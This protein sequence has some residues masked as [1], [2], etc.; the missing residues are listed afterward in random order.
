MQ[1]IKPKTSHGKDS[2]TTKSSRYFYFSIALILVLPHS[3]NRLNGHENEEVPCK[4]KDLS[5]IPISQFLTTRDPF[6]QFQFPPVFHHQASDEDN[7]TVFV[8]A[9]PNGMPENMLKQHFTAFGGQVGEPRLYEATNGN[10]WAFLRFV[11]SFFNSGPLTVKTIK[12]DSK[13]TRMRTTRVSD[14]AQ[15]FKSSLNL[16]YNTCF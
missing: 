2:I 6:L 13:S 11:T 7:V 9:L 3:K 16:F 10:R 1:Q 14:I 4:N 12:H 8:T 5:R 15:N